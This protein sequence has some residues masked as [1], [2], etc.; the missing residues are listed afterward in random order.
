MLLLEPKDVPI[1][2]P[3]GTVKMYTISKFPA[4]VGREIC[5][6]Y[7]L[8]AIPKLGD[9]GRNEELMFKMMCYVGVPGAAPGGEPLMLTTEQLVN[10]HIP[11]FE[12][13]LRLEMA[14]MEYNCSFFARGKA[15]SWLEVLVQKV[16]VLV[17]QTLMDYSARSSKSD[18]R[19]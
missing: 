11:D 17:T 18:T 9:Y 13:L 8:A 1:T 12:S 15:S 19:H 16:Q 6:Q 10:S 14:M 2:L 3:S 7:P 5:T 4:T